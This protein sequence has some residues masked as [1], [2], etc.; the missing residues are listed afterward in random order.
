[1]F[2]QGYPTSQTTLRRTM[3]LSPLRSSGKNEVERAHPKAGIQASDRD[4]LGSKASVLSALTRCSPPSST[5]WQCTLIAGNLLGQG[6]E[7]SPGI[8]IWKS[9]NSEYCHLFSICRGITESCLRNCLNRRIPS[10][11]T[12]STTPPSNSPSP[13]KNQGLL[14]HQGH[15]YCGG[16]WNNPESGKLQVRFAKFH[17]HGLTWNVP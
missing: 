4:E 8:Q 9:I 12:I 2:Y 5:W 10:Q 6:G 15:Q 17:C 13:T 7:W 14:H 3:L 1:M 16:D 11:S